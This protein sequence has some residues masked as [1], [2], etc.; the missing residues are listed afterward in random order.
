M[1]IET[2]TRILKES[3]LYVVCAKTARHLRGNT[4]LQQ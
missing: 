2:K 3:V 4:P 1:G